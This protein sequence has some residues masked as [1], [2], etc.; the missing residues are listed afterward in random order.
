MY[1]NYITRN[2]GLSDRQRLATGRHNAEAGTLLYDC[3]SSRTGHPSNHL[4]LIRA[5][6]CLSEPNSG[7]LIQIMAARGTVRLSPDRSWNLIQEGFK[8]GGWSCGAICKH[9]E[10]YEP[11]CGPNVYNEPIH[12]LK[13]M[14]KRLASTSTARMMQG[15]VEHKTQLYSCDYCRK[16]RRAC[17]RKL[18]VCQTCEKRNL[19]C[20]YSERKDPV[21]VNFDANNI[22]QRKKLVLCCAIRDKYSD[23]VCLLYLHSVPRGLG[24]YQICLP[25]ADNRGQARPPG[26]SANTRLGSGQLPPRL[27][28]SVRATAIGF[29]DLPKE[30]FEEHLSCLWDLFQN[31][32]SVTNASWSL[33]FG[34]VM[35][36]GWSLDL[37]LFSLA[38]LRFAQ[39][40]GNAYFRSV[41]LTAYNHSL[42]LFR[43]LV[44]HSDKR[45]DHILATI[46]LVYA[47]IEG[48]LESPA[49]VFQSGL[50]VSNPHLKGVDAITR[51]CD[52][53]KF[54]TDSHFPTFGKLREMM[55]K[56]EPI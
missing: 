27:H 22:R 11:A 25:W 29:L 3:E 1:V 28:D 35:R 5:R 49:T 26:A 51:R 8:R 41:S 55:V 23:V 43:S 52:P 14:H 6:P 9:A 42:A 34:L 2:L 50:L 56:H 39:T 33:G 31:G 15:A 16:A 4:W 10:I 32:H 7:A 46:A 24:C 47:M 20:G 18:P 48:C 13:A 45:G 36:K 19:S 44:G 17:D 21:F 37:A 53:I 30:R 54:Q 12:H 38:V 40:S